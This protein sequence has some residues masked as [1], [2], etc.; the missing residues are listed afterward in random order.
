MT[1]QFRFQD[2]KIWQVG[3]DLSLPLFHLADEL[4]NRKRFRFSEQLRGAVLSITNNIAEG[5]GSG[6]DREFQQFL[7]YSRRSVFETANI[8]IMLVREG[9]MQTADAQP[10]LDVL[11]ELSRMITSFSRS[12]K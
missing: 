1:A 7:N 9:S 2:M 6:S 11:E 8:L 10:H 3:A 12:L 5:S 4:E